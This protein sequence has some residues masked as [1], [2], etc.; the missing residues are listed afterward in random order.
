M[1]SETEYELVLSIHF[2]D[3]IT[4]NIIYSFMQKNLLQPN[5]NRNYGD[6]I[7]TLSDETFTHKANC[8]DS[9]Y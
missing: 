2:D 1:K 7:F 3:T 6:R 5:F 4:S 9:F 8:T